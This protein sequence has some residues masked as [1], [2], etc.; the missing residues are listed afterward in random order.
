MLAPFPILAVLFLPVMAGYRVLFPW[1]H[2]EEFLDEGVR[3]GLEHRAPYLNPGFFFARA[4]IYF[5]IWI[6]LSA[7]LRRWSFEQ[8]RAENLEASR[9]TYVV[10]A[11]ALPIVGLTIIFSSVDWLMALSPEWRS[12]MFP[13]YVFGSGFVGAIALLT[14]LTY[15][16]HRA[17]FLPELDTS[18]YYALGRLLLAFTIFW[19]YAAFFQLMLIWIA[20]EP[21]EAVFFL[22]RWQG[23]WKGTSI[24]LFFARFG[25]P[26]ILLMPYGI[27]RRPRRLTRMAILI[28]VATYIDFHWLVM[29]AMHRGGSPFNLFDLATAAV[30]GGLCTAFAVWRHAGRPVVP[31]H[32]PRLAEAFAYRS[33]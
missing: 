28:V 3:R 1:G 8:D 6:A 20:N 10:S 15:A 25:V 18:H 12:T 19:A 13:V 7:V 30:V 24:L 31:L 26:F 16:A 23:V 4:V 27:K 14:A 5:A 22:E 11:F 21:G 2:P 32:D 9:K 17:G 33:V 29:P